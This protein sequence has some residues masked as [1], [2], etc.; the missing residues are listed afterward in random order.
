MAFMEYYSL[1]STG[2]L[3]HCV[4]DSFAP[5]IWRHVDGE[6]TSQVGKCLCTSTSQSKSF[7]C[8]SRFC[9]YNVHLFEDGEPP[10]CWEVLG[11]A[12]VNDAIV[13]EY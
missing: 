5:R 9:N 1:L 10:R 6:P 12:L 3:N 13:E 4:Q 2:I 8:D 11:S 7:V